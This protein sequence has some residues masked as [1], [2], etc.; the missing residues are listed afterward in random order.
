MASNDASLPWKGAADVARSP[1]AQRRTMNAL[2][3]VDLT[4]TPRQRG[5]AH[6]ES[7]RDQ[8]AE[9]VDRWRDVVALGAAPSAEIYLDGLLADTDF[10]PAIARWTPDL[11]EEID[12]IAEGA[13]QP[14]EVVYALQLLDEDWW[15]RHRRGHGHCSSLAIA[16]HD[17]RA[18]WV[19][20]TMDLPQW[21]DGLQAMLRI[22]DADGAVTYVGTSAGMIGLLGVNRQ[23]GVCV[24]TLLQLSHDPK[25]LPVACVVRGLLAQTGTGAARAF[26]KTANHASG[27][28][29]VLGD[30][31]GVTMYECSAGG[32]VEYRPDA[33]RLWHTNDPLVSQDLAVHNPVGAS[34]TNQC[35]RFAAMER[36]LGEPQKSIDLEALKAVL[37]SRDDSAMPISRPPNPSSPAT[38]NCTI[39]AVIFEFGDATTLHY[40]AG[41]PS[42]E[43]EWVAQSVA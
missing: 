2:P 19:A 32:K 20:Q 29:Y 21:H 6:G 11:L 5:H 17:G 42:S 40:A 9:K 35:P 25:G 37:A 36:R 7:L 18:A 16:P 39:L 22:A 41:A 4:G 34:R 24:N 27:Q 1:I 31:N 28:N 15:Y 13:R 14:A 23:F 3:I 26:L 10:R 12:G 33:E 43:T 8:I 38:A 30:R